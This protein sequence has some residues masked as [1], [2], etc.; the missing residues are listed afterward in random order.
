M[1]RQVRVGV[2][3]TGYW[4]TKLIREYL[5]LQAERRDVQLAAIADSD[6][7]RL[8]QTR[9][10]FPS[11]ANARED[12]RTLLQ[13]ASIGAVHI[14]VPNELHYAVASEAL[15]AGKHVLLEKPLTL[16]SQEAY[17]L[18]EIASKSNRIF[19][20]GHIFQFNNAISQARRLVRN[21]DLGRVYAIRLRWTNHLTPLPERDILFDLAPHPIDIATNILGEWPHKVTGR[22]RSYVRGTPGREEEAIAILDFPDGKSAVIEMSWIA[23]GEKVREVFIRGS[24]QTLR[25]DALEQSIQCYRGD[26]GAEDRVPVEANNTIRDELASFV[27]HILADGGAEMNSGAYIGAKTVEVIEALRRSIAEDRTIYVDEIRFGSSANAP[28]AR[29]QA[30]LVDVQ[31][32]ARTRIHDY[33]NLYKCT[34]GDDVKIDSYVYIEEGVTIG[35]RSK[36]RAGAFIPTGVTIGREVFIGPGVLFTN[37]RYPHAAGE[38]EQED[39]VVEDGASIGA[40]AVIL[41]GVRV[42]ARAMV[43][44]GAVVTRDVA[45]G[46]LV[47]G[48][49]AKVLRRVSDPPEKLRLPRPVR[50]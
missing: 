22:G 34:L 15:A 25:I 13:D 4:G 5:A 14:A 43:A 49:P 23:P 8:A 10:E 35:D 31:V 19:Q 30:K 33:A 3:G 6:P 29:P 28:P 42:G 12:F 9:A 2:I 41:P 20:V 32:G 37:D 17:R 26:G 50:T 40:G 18:V 46:T 44:A 1:T 36:V 48:N 45:P 27:D 47:A 7:A 38:W 24:N 21:G 11:V 16:D 39:T